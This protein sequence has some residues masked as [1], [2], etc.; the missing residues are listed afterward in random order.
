ML[1]EDVTSRTVDLASQPDGG[2]RPAAAEVE[3][4]VAQSCLLPHGHVLV[5]GERQRGSGAQ[6]LEVGGHDLHLAGDEVGVD[7]VVVA[8]HDLARHPDA[9]LA[10]QRVRGILVTHDHLHDA[11]GVTQIEEHHPAVVAPGGHPPG[12]GHGLADVVGTQGAGVVGA[13]H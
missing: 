11:A 3:V 2:G 12:E 8:A 13:D 7:V 5:D 10:A 4:A 1:V 9:V 6:H